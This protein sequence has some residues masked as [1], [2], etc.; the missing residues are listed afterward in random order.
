V[1]AAA[2]RLLES[3]SGFAGP[4]L[5]PVAAMA[6]DLDDAAGLPALDELLAAGMVRPGAAPE[7]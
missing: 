6:A 4:F 7:R 3:G 5:F 1:P 2:N